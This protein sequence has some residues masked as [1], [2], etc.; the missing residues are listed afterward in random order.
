[1][2]R[3]NVEPTV[4]H[5]VDLPLEDNSFVE[6]PSEIYNMQMPSGMPPHVLKLKPGC[7]VI[8]LRNINVGQGLCNGSRLI[9]KEINEKVRLKVPYSNAFQV[10]KCELISP[11]SRDGAPVF[12]P[13][14]KLTPADTTDPTHAF[15]RLQF[16]LR[17]AYAL[18]INKSQGQTLEKVR[19]Y[20]K[21][22]FSFAGRL[23]APIAA[24][25]PRSTLC[26]HVSRLGHGE[27]LRLAVRR[28]PWQRPKAPDRS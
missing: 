19:I 18:T 7:V 25:Q 12:I 15:S 27:A 14:M 1:M 20:S 11:E 22:K 8:L 23:G 5:S 6:L 10:L 13:R 24:V 21:F 16:P 2:L 3:P 4:F 28:R 9:V 17:L 26:G